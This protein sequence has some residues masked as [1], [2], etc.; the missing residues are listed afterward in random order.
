MYAGHT[1]RN[2]YR[3]PYRVPFISVQFLTKIEVLRQFPQNFPTLNS[4]QLRSSVNELFG[5]YRWLDRPTIL[6][7]TP[8]IS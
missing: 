5:A 6:S 8:Q 1:V 7:G 3:S 4:M 2:A